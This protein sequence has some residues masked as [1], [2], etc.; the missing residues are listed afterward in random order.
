MEK[1]ALHKSTLTFEV[2]VTSTHGLIIPVYCRQTGVLSASIN[3]CEKLM[4]ETEPMGKHGNGK[5]WPV[6]S[7]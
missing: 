4:V 3:F 5:T 2:A 6:V 7:P 1:V